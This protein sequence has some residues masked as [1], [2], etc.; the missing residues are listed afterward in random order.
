MEEF[1]AKELIDAADLLLYLKNKEID[2]E[3]ASILCEQILKHKKP[4]QIHVPSNTQHYLLGQYKLPDTLPV[5]NLLSDIGRCSL[6][7]GKLLTRSDVEDGQSRLILKKADVHEFILP[8]LKRGEDTK[9]GIH[10]TIY[11]TQGKMYNM[12]FKKWCSKVY[13]LTT[14][15]K[16]FYHKHGLKEEEDFVKIWVFRHNKTEKLC[17]IISSR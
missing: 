10:V 1:Y 16:I 8:L 15:W 7:F 12:V 6:P 14:G 3:S 17:F 13:V 5:R 11:D 9:K 4:L 2:T